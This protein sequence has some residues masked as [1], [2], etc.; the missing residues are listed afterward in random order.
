MFGFGILTGLIVLP[1]VGAAFT[2]QSPASAVRNS[3]LRA[4]GKLGAPVRCRNSWSN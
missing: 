2:A 1:L 4:S 3:S